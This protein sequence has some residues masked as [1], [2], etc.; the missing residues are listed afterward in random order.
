M[1]I[2]T[3]VDVGHWFAMTGSDGPLNSQFIEPQTDTER[4]R[5]KTITDHVRHDLAARPAGKFSI[6]RTTDRYRAV[7]KGRAIT[8]Q[9]R[10]ELAP[11]LARRRIS[12]YF[13]PVLG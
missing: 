2:A 6:Y 5:V 11:G 9:P 13:P 8:D 3:E 10:H 1:E 4:V 7:P 12:L